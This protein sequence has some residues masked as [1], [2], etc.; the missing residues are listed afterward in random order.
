MSGQLLACCLFVAERVCRVRTPSEP[1]QPPPNPSSKTIIIPISKGYSLTH[2]PFLAASF[3][4]SWLF[5]SP[6]LDPL[7]RPAAASCRSAFAP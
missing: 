4:V 1:H 2:T 7:C 5:C 3:L 6:S